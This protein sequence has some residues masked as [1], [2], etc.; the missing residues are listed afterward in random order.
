MTAKSE[1]FP[2][3]WWRDGWPGG[4]GVALMMSLGLIFKR[5]LPLHFAMGIGGFLG[6]F[7]VGLI[8]N[9]RNAAKFGLPVWLAALVTG[10]ITGLCFGLLSYY[11]PW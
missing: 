5:W 4:L 7:V 9:T 1:N 6:W 8:Y 11:F 10:L 2:W 3:Y